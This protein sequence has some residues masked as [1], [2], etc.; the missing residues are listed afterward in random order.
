[1]KR[2]PP[3][4]RARYPAIDWRKIAGLRDMLIHAYFGI[5]LEI[6]WDVVQNKVPELLD[7]IGTIRTDRTLLPRG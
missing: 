3:E 6:L 2:L 7:Q 1:M 4:W 5:D